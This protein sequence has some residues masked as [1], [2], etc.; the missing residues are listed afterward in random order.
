MQEVTFYRNNE[1]LRKAFPYEI[2]LAIRD[3]NHAYYEIKNYGCLSGNLI[4]KQVYELDYW[5]FLDIRGGF[6]EEMAY[7]I[8]LGSLVVLIYM[9]YLDKDGIYRTE[10]EEAERIWHEVNYSIQH[11][12]PKNKNETD[13]AEL[14]KFLMKNEPDTELSEEAKAGFQL[15]DQVIIRYFRFV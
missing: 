4:H 11:L 1:P 6:E 5:V 12:K 2:D 15:I 8:R 7:K 3:I 10:D 13:L 9:F 14:L